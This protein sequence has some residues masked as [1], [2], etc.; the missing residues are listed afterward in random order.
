MSVARYLS[1]LLVLVCVL[2]LVGAARDV[3]GEA[4]PQPILDEASPPVAAAP[5]A[6]VVASSSPL[7]SVVI[8]ALRKKLK[9]EHRRYLQAH[10]RV[11]QL[12]RTLHHA[13]STHEAITLACIVYGSCSTLWRRASCE[14]GFSSY[15]HNSSGASGLFQFLPST[16][17]S[18]PFGSL[19]VWSPYA[20][21]LAAGW[22]QARGRGGEWVCK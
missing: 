4:Q 14:S 21:A 2:W 11:R 15:A 5:A 1:V 18:T 17:A 13:T 10:R 9:H 8:A 3:N 12:T 20:N 16:W 7:S 19:S 22:M 6:A